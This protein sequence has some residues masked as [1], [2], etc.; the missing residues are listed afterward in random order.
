MYVTI[1]MQNSRLNLKTERLTVALS[2]V[3]RQARLNKT[4]DTSHS[5][6]VATGTELYGAKVDGLLPPNF[7]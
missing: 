7:L 5:A 3:K 1:Q 4:P 2:K 6:Y